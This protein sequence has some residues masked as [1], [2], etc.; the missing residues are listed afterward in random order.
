MDALMRES[1]ELSGLPPAQFTVDDGWLGEGYGYPTTASVAAMERAKHVNL[2]VEPTY[3]GKA[4]A[5]ALSA[6]EGTHLYWH[7]HSSASLDVLLR[8]A[9]EIDLSAW[10]LE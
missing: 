5:A 4:L 1:A 8:G 10:R 9:P 3:T 6:G 7:T 2:K